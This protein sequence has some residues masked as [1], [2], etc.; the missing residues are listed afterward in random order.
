MIH[1]KQFYFDISTENSSRP[2]W[3]LAELPN[4]HNDQGSPDMIGEVTPWS[5]K[6]MTRS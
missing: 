1:M 3:E 5:T 2:N 4:R 6:I